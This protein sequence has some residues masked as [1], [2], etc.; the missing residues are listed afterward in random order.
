MFVLGTCF[1]YFLQVTSPSCHALSPRGSSPAPTLPTPT[2]SN[3][4]KTLPHPDPL[5]L[6]TPPTPT[7]TLPVECG[8]SLLGLSIV[9]GSTGLLQLRADVVLV[10]FPQV[11]DHELLSKVLQKQNR[12]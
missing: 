8:T 10:Q 4:A 6:H 7:P 9:V 11:T 5:P 3:P 1:S 12:S 2:Y